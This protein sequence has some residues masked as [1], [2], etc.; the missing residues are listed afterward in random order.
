MAEEGEGEEE[1]EETEASSAM[2]DIWPARFGNWQQTETNLS[3]GY[4]VIS[5]NDE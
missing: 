3:L 1:G 5:L 4:S 2:V